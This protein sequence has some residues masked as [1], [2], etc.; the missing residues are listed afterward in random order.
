VITA[1]TQTAWWL[2]AI[3]SIRRAAQLHGH[4]AIRNSWIDNMS[5]EDMKSIP[6][7]GV[8]PAAT[9]RCRRAGSRIQPIAGDGNE[10]SRATCLGRGGQYPADQH[11]HWVDHNQIRRVIDIYVATRAKHCRCG[12]AN[13]RL[14]RHEA[15][16]NT[17]IDVRGAVVSMNQAFHDSALPHHAILLVYFDS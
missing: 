12:R 9:A 17:V 5:M 13:Q 10:N 14:L 8:R 6:L 3:G 2:P 4:G 1:L 7:R 16:K 15:H 11:A